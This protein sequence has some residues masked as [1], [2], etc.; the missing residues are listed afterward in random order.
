MAAK[1][2]LAALLRAADIEI[3]G[4]D[5]WDIRVHDERFYARVLSD[6]SLGAGES[7]MDGWWD[8]PRLDE[9]F[10]RVHRP[11]SSASSG[12]PGSLVQVALS[13]IRNLQGEAI[14]D[15]SRGGTTTSRTTCTSR[16]S[17]RP[18]NTHAPTTAST[19]SIARS[20]RRSASSST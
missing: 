2:K 19:A 17:A 10:A 1:D 15:A 8:V 5:P 11:G 7:Y 9:F 18:C 14:Q 13:K 20:T 16:C 3:D 12:P 4:G 6:G